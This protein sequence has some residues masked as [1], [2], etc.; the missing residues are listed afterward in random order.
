MPATALAVLEVKL[1]PHTYPMVIA[2]QILLYGHRLQWLPGVGSNFSLA[3][4]PAYSL[5]ASR[6][7]SSDSSVT[8]YSRI[9]L[10]FAQIY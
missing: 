10:L 7:A 2:G 4:F 5:V 8:A 9:V 3:I 6:P 1:L